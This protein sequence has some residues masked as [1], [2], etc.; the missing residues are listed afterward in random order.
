MKNKTWLESFGHALDGIYNT[1][2]TERNFRIQIVAGI[3]A[4]AVCVIF[5]LPPWQYALVAM[6]ITLVLVTELLNTAI[7]AITDLATQGEIHSLAKKA[8]DAAAAAVL[9]ASTFALVVGTI[10][11]A[12]IIF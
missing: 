8:K 9:L 2:K 1:A 12:T 5:T 11:A 3:V 7:E 4:V 6:A 10:V